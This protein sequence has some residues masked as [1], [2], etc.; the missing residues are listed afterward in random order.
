MEVGIREL[1]ARLSLYVSEAADGATI[2]ITD[3]G[4]PVARLTAINEAS[5]FERGL[6]E[7]W[8]EPAR[9]TRLGKANPA[10]A[11]EPIMSVLDEDRG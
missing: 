5:H 1:K 2:V 11:K 9:R 7:G 10:L 6:D 3:R 8:I 4:K